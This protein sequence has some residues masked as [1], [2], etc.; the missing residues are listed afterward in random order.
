MSRE[1]SYWA[2][3]QAPQT[4]AAPQ[5]SPLQPWSE[6]KVVGKPLQRIDAYERVSGSA[7][8]SSDVI[9]RDMLH[10]ATLRCP[11]AH[12]RVKKVDTSAAEKLPG[13]WAIIT[14]QTPGADIPWYGGRSGASRLFD[15][16][17]RFEGEEVAAVAA[18]TPYQA[19]DA[20]RAIKVEYEVL[21][22]VSTIEEAL[23]AG[24]PPVQG[25]SNKVAEPQ[26]YVRGSIEAGFAAADVVRERTYYTECQVHN[27]MES[28]GC[29][30][31]WDGRNYL[32]IWDTTQGVFPVQQQVAQLLKLPLANVRVIG[33]YMG[34]G[35]GAKLSAS[36]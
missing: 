35:F 13:V 14:D 25:T 18:E 31:K 16:H 21:P 20:V 8:F 22:A 10:G 28:F 32:T 26:P 7:T 1:D 36:K 19:W 5:P 34:G 11:H 9:V 33:H 4:P 6:T 30:A 17:C 12:A 27:P 3:E 23:A 15:P 29:V 2:D 24:A